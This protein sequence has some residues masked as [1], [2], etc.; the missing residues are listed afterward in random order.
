MGETA[1]RPSV[2]EA[3]RLAWRNRPNGDERAA[4]EHDLAIA[5]AA[6]GD[7]G[8]AALLGARIALGLLIPS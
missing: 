6:M 8:Q 7:L 4:H 1:F 2:V 3:D 5:I